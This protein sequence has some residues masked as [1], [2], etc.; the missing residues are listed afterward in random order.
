[1][2]EFQNLKVGDE[3]I[4]ISNGLGATKYLLREV[5]RLTKTQIII[6][7]FKYRRSDG[8]QIG[9]NSYYGDRLSLPTE[10]MR[11]KMK[12]YNQSLLKWHCIND[13]RQIDF[14]KFSFEQLQQIQEFISGLQTAVKDGE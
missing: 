1:M 8:R 5:E 10:T 9:Y 13:L 6:D 4:L 11:Q 3:V 2:S 14:N 7:N 12:E